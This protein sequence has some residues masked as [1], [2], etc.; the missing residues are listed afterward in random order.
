MR[1]RAALGIA[2]GELRC[3]G[4]AENIALAYKNNLA[5]K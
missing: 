2:I 4:L 5:A 1:E 3:P